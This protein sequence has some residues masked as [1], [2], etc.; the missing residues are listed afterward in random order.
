ML[1]CRGNHPPI[2]QSS[3]LLTPPQYCCFIEHGLHHRY[4]HEKKDMQIFVEKTIKRAEDRY[5]EPKSDRREKQRHVEKIIFHVRSQVHNF[6]VIFYWVSHSAQKKLLIRNYW[7]YKNNFP[8]KQYLTL[9]LIRWWWCKRQI[10]PEM[11][12]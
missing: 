5:L 12:Q 9:L 6:Q 10:F 4:N 8:S 7:N 11:L 3:H 1:S 2:P